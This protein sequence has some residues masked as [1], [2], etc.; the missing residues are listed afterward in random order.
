[1]N[2]LK[3]LKLFGMLNLIQ[4]FQL[5]ER[6]QLCCLNVKLQ[7]IQKEIIFLIWVKLYIEIAQFMKDAFINY[8]HMDK[9]LLKNFLKTTKE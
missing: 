6:L 1:M 8:S 2:I 3:D 9:G 4:R 5:M 7:A